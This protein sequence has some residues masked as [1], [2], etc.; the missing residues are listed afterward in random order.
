M[1]G[2]TDNVLLLL[3]C[4]PRPHPAARCPCCCRPHILVRGLMAHGVA[5]ALLNAPQ[6]GG[7]AC[8][9]GERPG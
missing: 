5:E 4:H 2:T 9:P 8:K 3:R 6:V 7:R 1:L